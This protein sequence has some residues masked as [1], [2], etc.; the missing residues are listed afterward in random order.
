[1]ARRV[2]PELISPGMALKEWSIQQSAFNHLLA[3]NGIKPRLN[4]GNGARFYCRK[5]VRP[6]VR[7]YMVELLR[8]T[9]RR[10]DDINNAIEKLDYE[11]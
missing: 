9:Q 8:E 6:L 4:Q 5:T 2:R 7:G 3:A 11:E 10:C 1:M